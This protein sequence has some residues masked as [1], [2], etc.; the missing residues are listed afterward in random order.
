MTPL[1]RF[2]F[3]SVMLSLP[4]LV[5]LLLV[6]GRYTWGYLTFSG[7]YCGG[8]A[9]LDG[10]I[11][12]VLKP[13]TRACVGGKAPF[14]S[15][16]WFEAPVHTDGNGF[17]AAEPGGE[18]P[19]GGILAVGDSWTFGYGVA[20]NDSFPGR[21]QNLTGLPA[22]TAASPAYSG[23]QAAL[24]ARRWAGPLT[25]NALVY[26]ELGFWERGAC[27][28]RTRP[29]HI[30]K[31]CFWTDPETGRAELVAPP[32]GY[33]ERM[34]AW[35]VLPGGMVGAGEKT[36][37]YFLVSRPVAKVMQYAVRAGFVSGMAHDFAARGVDAPAI[38]QA[39]LHHLAE[40]AR[41]AGA[42]LILLDPSNIHEPGVAQLTPDLAAFVHRVPAQRWKEAVEAP[43]TAL[44]PSQRRVPNDGHFGPGT[45]HLIAKLLQEELIRIGVAP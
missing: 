13:A 26:L 28:G 12:W 5:A 2:A 40:T 33:V 19:Q 15:E 23:A 16:V 9:E 37:T 41:T 6:A 39:L 44:P 27:S 45:N 7:Y 10:E 35:G 18:P 20:W 1:R 38:L 8:F 24:L 29:K 11:G 25:P 17:R 36:L 3:W 34:A 43:A 31:P 14:R 21:L 30:L 22:V 42:P 32:A 4:F